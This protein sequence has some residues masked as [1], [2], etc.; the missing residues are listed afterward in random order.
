[1][2]TSQALFRSAFSLRT[3]RAARL[4]L[5][6]FAVALCVGASAGC[7]G[8]SEPGGSD[9]G[10]SMKNCSEQHS[11][12]NGSCKCVTGPN[13]DASCCD[14]NDSSCANSSSRCDKDCEVCQ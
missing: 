11:C 4:L 3:R 13:K 9:G 7:G 1:M 14:P 10:T 6:A 2:S 12:V 5:S 8:T